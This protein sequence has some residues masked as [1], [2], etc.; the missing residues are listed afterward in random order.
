MVFTEDLLWLFA[1]L[2][3]DCPAYFYRICFRLLTGNLIV[4]QPAIADFN[5][6]Y[7]HAPVVSVVQ[8]LLHARSTVAATIK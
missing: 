2:V 7:Y 6:K 8:S 1:S 5:G 4:S 3:P